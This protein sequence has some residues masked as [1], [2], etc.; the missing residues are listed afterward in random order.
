MTARAIGVFSLVLAV[1]ST[2]LAG[3]KNSVIGAKKLEQDMVH[4]GGV[5]YPSMMYEWW[6]K[7]KKEL[8]WGLS[9]ELVYGG[10]WGAATVNKVD[11]GVFTFRANSRF[12]KIGLGINGMLRWH[13][14]EKQ[15]PK[16]TN[17]IGILFKP[18]VLVASNRFA[19]NFTFGIKAELGAPVSIDVHEARVEGVRS[20]SSKRGR[21]PKRFRPRSLPRTP[22]V[23]AT[24]RRPRRRPSHSN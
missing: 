4:S 21:G 22:K 18:G 13:L 24:R 8:D 20:M 11:V 1:A 16:V 3:P 19:N 23:V 14:A 6:N 2:A 10:S 12:I 17:D 9:G 5:G 7:G 15:R